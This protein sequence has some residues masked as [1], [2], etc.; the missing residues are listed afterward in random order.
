MVSNV[1]FGLRVVPPAHGVALNLTVSTRPPL[2]VMNSCTYIIYHKSFSTLP[3]PLSPGTVSIAVSPCNVDLLPVTDC[4]T[5]CQSEYSWASDSCDSGSSP[6]PPSVT[7]PATPY[8]T[9]SPN[10]DPPPDI[11]TGDSRVVAYV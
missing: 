6:T 8:P 4:G 5:G 3:A 1:L 11:D 7:P 9:R 10:N 2:C